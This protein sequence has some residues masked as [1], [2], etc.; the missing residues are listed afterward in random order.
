MSD[1]L[2]LTSAGLRPESETLLRK[3][4]VPEDDGYR[5][6]HNEVGEAIVGPSSVDMNPTPCRHISTTSVTAMMIL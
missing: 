5:G 6:E 4:N 3:S 1:T 2:I